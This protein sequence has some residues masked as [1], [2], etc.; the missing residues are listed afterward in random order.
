[1][2]GRPSWRDW[3]VVGACLGCQ[4]GMGAGGYIFP[5]FLT[6]V[7]D[8]LGWSRTQYALA[9]PIMSTTVALAAPLVGWAADR[10]G[11]RL[12]LAL[13]S[14]LMSAALLAAGRMR[15]PTDFYLV[16]LAVGVAVA[17][18]GDLPTGAAVTARF[19]AR[20]GLA[21][22]MVFIGSNIGGALVPLVGIWLA[23]GASWRTAF[24][25]IGAALLLTLPLALSVGRPPA[26]AADAAPAERSG[27]RVAVG[28]RDFW[29][30]FWVLFAFYGLF[31]G[32]TEGTEKALL[33]DL[34]HPAER[35]AAFGWYNFAIGIGALP[36]SLL[37]GAIWQWAGAPAAFGFGAGLAALAAL[38]LW[39]LVR[40]TH[41]VRGAPAA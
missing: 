12:V 14:L 41:T 38:L 22:G 11:P 18:L 7:S 40:D 34:A 19:R 5:V 6:P 24:T 9:N 35:G 20:R 15:T 32:L 10:R 25:G 39:G 26:A 8:E 31:Y 37:F 16:A 29:L 21:L 4:V 36:A 27:W 28:Q 13:G 2:A 1:M 30:L 33:V 3:L 23:A 17:C